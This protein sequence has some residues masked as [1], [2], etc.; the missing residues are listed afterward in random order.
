MERT[1]FSST[2]LLIDESPVT[3]R[4][5]LISEGVVRSMRVPFG[6]QNGKRIKGRLDGILPRAGELNADS[7]THALGITKKGR[8]AR[9]R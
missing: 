2:T 1:C 3:G 6:L 7:V 8:S 4:V 9:A 5:R